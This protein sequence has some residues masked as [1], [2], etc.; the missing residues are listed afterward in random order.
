MIINVLTAIATLIGLWILYSNL[1]E[2]IPEE[3]FNNLSEEELY[4][5]Y[6]WDILGPILE[7]TFVNIYAI[8][9]NIFI[10]GL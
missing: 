6:R 3:D 5:K 10:A 9:Y 1:T 7:I 2:E 4:H 8:I